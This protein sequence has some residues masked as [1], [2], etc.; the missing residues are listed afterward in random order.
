[1]RSEGRTAAKKPGTLICEKWRVERAIRTTDQLAIYEAK[2]LSGTRVLL[3]V[4]H[5]Y[6]A[7]DATLAARM[8]REAYVGNRIK[9][10]AIVKVLGDGVTPEGSVAIALEWVEGETLEEYR[11]RR[12][13]LLPPDEVTA[14]GIT[15]CEALQAAHDERV[16]HRDVRPESFV[17]TKKG[18]LRVSEFSSARVIGEAVGDDERTAVGATIGGPAFMS[19]EQARGQRERVDMRSDVFSLG[20]TLYTLVSGK[21]VHVADNPLATLLAAS[22]EKAKPVRS[23]VRAQLPDALAD[24]IDRALKFEPSD[25]FP[26]MRTMK[27]ALAKKEGAPAARPPGLRTTG[28]AGGSQAPAGLSPSQRPPPP[29]AG[30]GALPRTQA[31][32]VSPSRSASPAAPAAP[33]APPP[34]A[35]AP[36]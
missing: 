31:S 18:E 15:L 26:S 9:H 36:A 16:I 30:R 2:D 21:T 22:R 5:P 23:V 3:K 28:P 34:A 14:F 10:P 35:A 12:G 25:R 11:V 13:G 33:S 6:K 7:D 4:I 19:P 20:A 27:N 1:M 32:A 29:L 17:V 24:A 8:K